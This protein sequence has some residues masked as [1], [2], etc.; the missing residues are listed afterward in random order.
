[1]A[2]VKTIWVSEETALSANNMN[3]I[4]QGIEAASIASELDST[5]ISTYTNLGW[6]APSS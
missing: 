1:M 2:Y 3:K 5:V 4:E 6:V